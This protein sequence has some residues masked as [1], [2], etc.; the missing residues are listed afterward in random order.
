MTYGSGPHKETVSFPTVCAT[1]Q[2]WNMGRRHQLQPID[3][4]SPRCQ[5]M[6]HVGSL[7]LCLSDLGME[8]NPP[9]PALIQVLLCVN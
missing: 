6:L 5:E 8:T 1:S 9:K 3:V 2:G 4:D 7:W